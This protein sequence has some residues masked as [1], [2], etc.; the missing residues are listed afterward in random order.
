MPGQPSPGKRPKQD[1]LTK[2]FTNGHKCFTAMQ[3]KFMIEI[4]AKDEEKRLGFEDNK[5]VC[6]SLSLSL[7]LSLCLCVSLSLCLCVSLP[8]YLCVSTSPSHTIA[9]TFHTHTTDTSSRQRA[10]PWR[11]S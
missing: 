11:V 6:L 2:R 4:M 9:L 5:C 3:S 1:P 8:L 10:I 7:S